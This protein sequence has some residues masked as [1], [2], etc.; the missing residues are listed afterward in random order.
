MKSY[1]LVYVVRPDLEPDALKAL[2]ERVTQ[3]IT[4]QGGAVEAVDQWGKR[5]MS[6]TTKKNREGIFV[7]TRFSIDPA[8]ITEIRHAVNLMEEVLR[9][10]LTN[11]VGKLPEP[12]PAEA[13]PAAPPAAA[14]PEAPAQPQGPAGA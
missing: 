6:F 2:V 8:K 10:I 14:P 4:D 5:R 1:D 7:H 12:K 3:R 13:P 9:A 11:A